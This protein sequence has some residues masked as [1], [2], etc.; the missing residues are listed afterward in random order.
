MGGDGG[1][2]VNRKEVPPVSPMP[3]DCC[4]YGGHIAPASSSGRCCGDG[5][6][7]TVA[8]MTSCDGLDG[9]SAGGDDELFG[10]V[11]SSTVDGVGV[12][13][14]DGEHENENEN[15]VDDDDRDDNDAAAKSAPSR[16]K[17]NVDG[18][19]R[20][21]DSARLAPSSTPTVST[22][23]QHKRR[24]HHD[25]DGAVAA[26]ATPSAREITGKKPPVQHTVPQR[27][28]SGSTNRR[29]ESG[30][31]AVT[32]GAVRTTAA[33]AVVASVV[34]TFS[35]CRQAGAAGIT[36]PAARMPAAAAT[37]AAA[38]ATA[39]GTTEGRVQVRRIFSFSVSCHDALKRG[40]QSRSEK[41]EQQQRWW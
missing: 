33:T 27:P 30:K 18:G 29:R 20:P 35:L 24:R 36:K 8:Y 38:G 19:H 15:D 16:K 3:L 31:G 40:N 23:M 32:R 37:A 25:V 7:D 4:S 10:I 6:D 5:G 39:M 22:T 1:M 17:D 9:D 34:S 12:I 11:L 26:P 2:D 28:R 13:S 14:G 21:L 41:H